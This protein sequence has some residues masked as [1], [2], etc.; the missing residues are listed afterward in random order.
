M[1]RKWILGVAVAALVLCA[2]AGSVLASGN[3][4]P[5]TGQT[6]TSVVSKVCNGPCGGNYADENADGICDRCTAQQTG[7]GCRNG[8]TD[9]NGDGVCD[10]YAEQGCAGARHG[11]GAGHRAGCGQ[12]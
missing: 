12:R 5:I 10:R 2:G 7:A 11:H 8:Y 1:K 4:G 3:S 6:Q 9:T